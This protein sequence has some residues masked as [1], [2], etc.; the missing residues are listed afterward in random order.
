MNKTAPLILIL[1]LVTALNLHAQ[2]LN[3]DAEG[4]STIIFPGGVIGLD[5]GKTSLSFDYN[6]FN[7]LKPK[8][9]VLGI[10][11]QA[12]NNSGVAKLFDT[13]KLTPEGSLSATVGYFSSRDTFKNITEIRKVR[14]RENELKISRNNIK[15]DITQNKYKE[16]F[17][18]H[19]EGLSDGTKDKIRAL[20]NDHYDPAPHIKLKT[21]LN[22]FKNANRAAGIEEAV[23]RI[24]AAINGR[25][26][27]LTNIEI[28]YN[29][30]K[31]KRIEME[32]NVTY[33]RWLGYVN[34]GFNASSFKLYSE[35]DS[36]DLSDH[37]EDKYFNGGFVNFGFNLQMKGDWLLGI[38]FGY[39]K[40]NNFNILSKS[41]KEYTLEAT[42][43]SQEQKLTSEKKITAYSG[44]YEEY[45]RLSANGDVIY[46]V[47]LG[48]NNLAFNLFYFRWKLPQ[49]ST[50]PNTLDIGIGGSFFSRTG[51]F[52]GGVYLEAPDVTNENKDHRELFNRLTFG[53]VVK[54]A[55]A[56]VSF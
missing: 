9:I 54:F 50:Y 8:G 19:I 2:I 44:N 25:L 21:E 35:T 47:E 37:F 3:Q 24:I 23:D 43:T 42:Q 38:S 31:E 1:V 39:E 30:T 18:A 11:A 53:I 7:T 10:R 41:K 29:K 14:K 27:E 32:K 22:N 40:T 34:F 52:L 51:K 33:Q 5:L 12:K 13:G 48:K 28:E 55:F 20:R 36:S 26:A 46:F 49:K 17:E 6:N 16:E 45:K 4:K 15:K 56:P